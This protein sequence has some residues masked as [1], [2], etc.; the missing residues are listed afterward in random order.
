MKN[1]KPPSKSAIRFA[2]LFLSSA[3]STWSSAYAEEADKALHDQLPDQIKSAG[4][5]RMGGAYESLPHLNAD[6]QDATKP[7]GIAPDIVSH[8]AP[9][10]GVKMDWVNTAWP[11]QIPGLRSGSL[12]VLMGQI[13]VTPDRE[14]A[15]MDFV[16]YYKSTSGALVPA[17]NPNH[18][19]SDV[20]SLCGL[21]IGAPAGSLMEKE[22][23]GISKKYCEPAGKGDIKMVFFPSAS[24]AS[25]SVL[26]GQSQAYYES[27]MTTRGIAKASDSRLEAVSMNYDQTKE[28][29]PGLYGLAVTKD[30]P[31]LTKA[32]LVAMQKIVADGSYKAALDK[33]DAGSGALSA[34]EVKINPLT[35]TPVGEVAH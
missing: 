21:T 33:Y 1:I 15:L 29:N 12:D 23:T 30:N 13:S 32:I 7:V 18:V 11:G 8:L 19:T 2:T 9:I 28:W 6:P 14:K 25:V 4:V 16:P 3:V 20:T 35:N 24:A 5:I 22:L 17:G 31:G 26:S 10:L 27:Y 34:D